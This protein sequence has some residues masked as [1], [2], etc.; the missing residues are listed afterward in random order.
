[1]SWRILS[2]AEYA[3]LP[4]TCRYG[5]RYSEQRLSRSF[6]GRFRQL[7]HSGHQSFVSPALPQEQCAAT[8]NQQ[9]RRRSPQSLRGNGSLLPLFAARSAMALH[10]TAATKWNSGK[11]NR[12]PELHHGLVEVTRDVCIEQRLSGGPAFLYVEIAM[13]QSGEHALD[14]SVHHGD[15]FSECDACDC[16]RRVSSDPG[17]ETKL[18]RTLRNAS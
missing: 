12:C 15:R 18:R 1:M 9:Y 13:E 6:P 4:I 5:M 3:D 2:G 7:P 17:Q 14:I 11:A 10:R 16:I 8:M